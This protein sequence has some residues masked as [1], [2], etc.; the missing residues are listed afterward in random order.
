M[1]LKIVGRPGWWLVL[2]FI[3]IVNIVITIIV[4]VDLAKS[5]GQGVGF[6]MGLIFLPYHLLPDPGLRHARYLG[7]A[8]L[9]PVAP[10]AASAAAPPLDAS[11]RASAATC[12]LRQRRLT[13]SPQ[14]SPSVFAT[15]LRRISVVP[16]YRRIARTSRYH[17]SR[18][19]SLM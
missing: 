12:A 19:I 2:Y 13:A 11:G 5:F 18:P 9:G 17:C 16:S 7:P 3:P 14:G 6:A 10:P 4:V 15:L 1:A 8:A